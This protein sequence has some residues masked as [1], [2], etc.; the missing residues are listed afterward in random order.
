MKM[1]LILCTVWQH[2]HCCRE[3]IIRNSLPLPTDTSD[4]QKSGA[5]TQFWKLPGTGWSSVRVAVMYRK[6]ICMFLHTVLYNRKSW[7]MTQLHVHG[8]KFLERQLAMSTGTAACYSCLQLGLSLINGLHSVWAE[9]QFILT[10]NWNLKSRGILPTGCTPELEEHAGELT[11]KMFRD[12][13]WAESS[14]LWQNLSLCSN[15]LCTIWVLILQVTLNLS[16][17]NLAAEKWLQDADFRHNTH[18]LIFSLETKPDVFTFACVTST[19]NNADSGQIC[20]NSE[21]SYG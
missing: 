8:T 5:S 14:G 21:Q 12:W 15:S 6:Y 20:W 11:K 18:F 1:T 4:G 16:K 2:I 3:H 17:Q 10:V 13:T 9:I 19:L 7:R